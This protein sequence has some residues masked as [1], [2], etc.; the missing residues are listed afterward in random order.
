[1]IMRKFTLTFLCLLFIASIQLFG[2]SLPTKGGYYRIRNFTANTFIGGTG[3]G[4]G[5]VIHQLG[6]V[7]SLYQIFKVTLNSS[8]GY[9][10]FQQKA[11]GLFITHD[12]SWNGSYA[13]KVA[14]TR[15]SW[16]IDNVTSAEY[17]TINRVKD[18]NTHTAGIGYDAATA[19]STLYMDKTTSKQNKWIFEPIISLDIADLQAL[20]NQATALNATALASQIT[21]ASAFLPSTSEADILAASATLQTAIDNL[22]ISTLLESAKTATQESPVNVTGLMVNPSFEDGLIGWTNTG[23]AL[24][25]NAWPKK[26]GTCFVEKYIASTATTVAGVANASISQSL[27]MAVPNGK[28]K[29]VVTAQGLQQAYTPPLAITPTGV[30]LFANLTSM[31]VGDSAVYTLENIIV[32]DKTLNLGIKTVSAT[33]NWI[34]ADNFQLYYQGVDLTALANTLSGLITTGSSITGVVQTAANAELTAAIAEANTVLSNRTEAALNASI[35]RM[36]SAINAVNASK[37]VYSD[38]SV[39]IKLAKDTVAKYYD[40]EINK[41]VV[42]AAIAKAQGVY[43]AHLLNVAG[44]TAAKD[45]LVK[46]VLSFQMDNASLNSPVV[47]N[48]LIVNPGFDS[49]T[50]TGWTGANGA[51]NYSEYELY[52]KSTIDFYQT[53]TGLRKGQYR[54]TVQ[55][56]HRPGDNSDAKITAHDDGSEVIPV[57]LYANAKTSPMLSLYADKTCSAATDTWVSGGGTIFAN[58]MATVRTMF[59]A[60]GYSGNSVIGYVADDG[61]LKF[62][63]KNTG[64]PAANSWTIYDNFQLSYVGL[65]ELEGYLIDLENIS[66]AARDFMNTIDAKTQV[67]AKGEKVIGKYVYADYTKLDSLITVVE[68]VVNSYVDQTYTGTVADVLTL[69]TALVAARSALVIY[70]PKNELPNGEY[71]IKVADMFYWNNPGIDVLVNNTAPGVGNAGLVMDLNVTTGS[72]IVKVA[73]LSGV[74]YT[75]AIDR[76]SMF[77]L[78]DGR[79]ITE[80]CVFQDSWGTWDGG[81]DDEWRTHNIYYNGLGYAVQAAGS[82]S[83]KGFWFYQSNDQ[84]VKPSSITTIADTNYVFNFIPVKTIFVGEVA[85]GRTSFNSAVVGAGSSQYSQVVYNAFKTALET[86]EA[87]GTAGTAKSS[88]L[89]AYE[90][91][92]QSFLKNSE[93]AVHRVTDEA[94]SVLGGKSMIVVKSESNQQVAI[95]SLTGTLVSRQISAGVHEITVAPGYYLVRI[96]NSISKVVVR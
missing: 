62:G 58:T 14:T 63:I 35:A 50:G 82:S 69:Q 43:D 27:K 96:N 78:L 60:G 11:S 32:V 49:N 5:S 23:F 70:L 65:P 42:N 7:D 21:A 91:A 73:K 33:A 12:N 25:T 61:I 37:I 64:T 59:T 18:D 34:A 92:L 31:E 72:Q 95:Y 16:Y 29:L 19:G 85:K 36:S 55:G 88:D 2:A 77:S 93:V 86:A 81:S 39:S 53:I 45:S 80:N 4:T 40:L 28:Y 44:T 79:N 13:A 54:V 6:S 56:F 9:Y 87:T 75:K 71:Y 51:G 47:L 17:C 10:S 30:S 15:Q 89:F 67:S 46:V 74:D 24:Q 3:T 22:N 52:N 84:T 66:I 57:A 90:T 8:N 76:Y 83:N 20:I 38:L 26:S 48:S 41:T 68:G 94:V 1:M